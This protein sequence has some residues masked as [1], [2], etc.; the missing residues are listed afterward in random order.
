[1]SSISTAVKALLHTS[2]GTGLISIPFFYKNN[3]IL[4]AVTLLTFSYMMSS[5]GLLLQCQLSNWLYSLQ[6]NK[7][8]SF[9]SLGD[10]LLENQNDSVV[11]FDV[12]IAIKCFGVSL[13]Y[14]IVIGDLMPQI[15]HFFAPD[16]HISRVIFISISLFVIILPLCFIKKISSLKK[17]S[18]IALISVVYLCFMIIGNYFFA[19]GLDKG[20]I[21]WTKPNKSYNDTNFLTSFPISVFAFTC[22]HNTFSIFNELKKPGFHNFA[23][24]VTGAMSLALI[25][26]LTVG[27]LGYLTFGD[28]VESNII[29]MYDM[30]TVFNVLGRFCIVV[31]VT[32]AYPLQ[33][34]P[35]RLSIHNI[36][37]HFHQKK[38]NSSN[39]NKN[40]KKKNYTPATSE[41]ST[42]LNEEELNLEQQIVSTHLEIPKMQFN[43]I[44]LSVII[45]GFMISISLTNLGLV[46]SFIGGTGSTLIAFIL[47]GFFSYLLFKKLE[48]DENDG[49]FVKKLI[50]DDS[51]SIDSAITQ[52]GSIKKW[53][54]LSIALMIYG[55]I[56]VIFAN[57]GIIYKIT[58]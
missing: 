25:I 20:K 28:L 12:A 44:T 41:S 48:E 2:L 26:Y 47:P 36:I 55:G 10:I 43:I 17:F 1:M 34:Y 16:L 5:I 21:Y 50:A 23:K 6:K 52:V 9:K 11:L 18:M 22:Q 15:I 46:L 30:S 35:C 14:L 57:A 3:G 4:L 33:M 38:N 54:L 29:K 27:T 19:T 13:S 37:N 53:K 45:L 8:L 39:N 31:L 7:K 32:L 49:S 51:L 56:V 24:V 58:H 40:S 42:L